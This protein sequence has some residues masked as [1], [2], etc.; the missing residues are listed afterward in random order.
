MLLVLGFAAIGVIT[1]LVVHRVLLDRLDAQLRAAGTR[2]AVGLEHNDRDADN[3][4][5]QFAIGR[6]PGD[7][8]AGRPHPRTGR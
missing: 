4:P 1:T 8:H 3:S 6:G 5:N 7:R 2:F